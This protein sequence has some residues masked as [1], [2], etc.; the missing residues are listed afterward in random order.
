MSYLCSVT[1]QQRVNACGAEIWSCQAERE[2]DRERTLWPIQ[3]VWWRC[4]F[5]LS[6][7]PST[8]SEYD[9]D[10]FLNSA[11]L[12]VEQTQTDT[13][14]TWERISHFN[15]EEKCVKPT[16]APPQPQVMTYVNSSRRGHEIYT[17]SYTLMEKSEAAQRNKTHTEALKR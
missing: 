12:V 8:R 9:S 11:S 10:H 4:G 1:P 17:W 2:R 6:L 15:W 3:G 13:A 7:M 14:S 5:G 16:A